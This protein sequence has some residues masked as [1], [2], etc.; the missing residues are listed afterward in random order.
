MASFH[1]LNPQVRKRNE[2]KNRL[3]SM[4]FDNMSLCLKVYFQD[5]PPK[6]EGKIALIIFFTWQ[7]TQQV[8]TCFKFEFY[9][10]QQFF[11]NFFSK[12]SDLGEMKIFVFE[13]L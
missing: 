11:M 12:I 8:Q 6:K 13:L 10:I 2:K 5:F 3:E 7:H 4:E 1:T 9:F